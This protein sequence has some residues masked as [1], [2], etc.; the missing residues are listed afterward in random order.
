M[1]HLTMHMS[2]LGRRLPRYLPYHDLF[3]S[4]VASTTLNPVYL[5][6]PLATIEAG[7][8]AMRRCAIS[9]LRP[10]APFLSS[11]SARGAHMGTVSQSLC[12]PSPKCRP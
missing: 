3:V 7:T 4:G 10:Y 11:S 8:I 5:D 6:A 12:I 1:L 2:I 9:P